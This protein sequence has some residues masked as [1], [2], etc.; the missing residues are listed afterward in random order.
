LVALDATGRALAHLQNRQAAWRREF[1]DWLIERR[2]SICVVGNAATLANTGLGPR[3][4]ANRC[5]VRFN[6]FQLPTDTS[7][8]RRGVPGWTQW[9]TRGCCAQGAAP[10][11]GH[12]M[13]TPAQDL[14]SRIDVLV[15]APDMV[16]NLLCGSYPARWLILSGC[17]VRYQLH[18]WQALL[19]LLDAGQK[20]LTVPRAPWRRLVRELHAPPSA[21]VLLLEWLIELAGDVKDITAAGFQDDRHPAQLSRHYHHAWPWQR[22]GRRHNWSRELALLQRWRADG[23]TGPEAS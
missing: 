11:V 23:L 16:G 21:G 22:A 5:V 20:I 13:T 6:R 1:A 7:S 2:G 4:D 18:D 15:C 10:F 19:P 3:I 9:F 12:G 17:D 8:P 14:G